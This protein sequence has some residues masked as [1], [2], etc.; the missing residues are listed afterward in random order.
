MWSCV[1]SRMRQSGVY[2]CARAHACPRSCARQRTTMGRVPVRRRCVARHTRCT[3]RGGRSPGLGHGGRAWRLDPVPGGDGRPR[4]SGRTDI[5]WLPERA[6]AGVVVTPWPAASCAQFRAAAACRVPLLDLNQLP[7]V[8]TG[9]CRGGASCCVL[10]SLAG[11]ST[12][13]CPDRPRVAPRGSASSSMSEHSPWVLTT[14]GD[15]ASHPAGSLG[16]HWP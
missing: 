14:P 16:P 13:L 15:P 10:L 9:A 2:E 4:V 1:S 8:R 5:S 12:E 7:P 6:S 11:R 3:W